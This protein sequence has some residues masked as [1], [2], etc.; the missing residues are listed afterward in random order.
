MCLIDRKKNFDYLHLEMSSSA[1]FPFQSLSFP[2][3]SQQQSV[4]EITSDL[5]DKKYCNIEIQHGPTSSQQQ[6]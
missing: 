5:F 3:S 4:E 6:G 2:M 1:T